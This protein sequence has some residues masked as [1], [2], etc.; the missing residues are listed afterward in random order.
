MRRSQSTNA[1]GQSK[2]LVRVPSNSKLPEMR[3]EA[4]RGG[5]VSSIPSLQHDFVRGS[6]AVQK[7]NWTH[8]ETNDKDFVDRQGRTSPPPLVVRAAK[9]G[10]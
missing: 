3:M 9:E 6:E 10:L 4:A 8:K 5:R 2:T 7:K 1:M